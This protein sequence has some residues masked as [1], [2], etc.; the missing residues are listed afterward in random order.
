M[1][2]Q[3]LHKKNVPLP[4]I[5]IQYLIENLDLQKN[6]ITAIAEHNYKN[7]N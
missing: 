2:S 7:G 1:K 6:Q 4:F 5:R 3:A